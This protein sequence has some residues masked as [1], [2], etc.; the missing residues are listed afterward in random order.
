MVIPLSHIAL[1]QQAEIVWL[2]AAPDMHQRLLDL[3]FEPEE[4]VSC[5]LKSKNGMSAYLVKHAVIAL[6]QKDAAGI[7]VKIP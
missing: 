5:V 4:T 7:F 3:G 2:A 1:N 6:R